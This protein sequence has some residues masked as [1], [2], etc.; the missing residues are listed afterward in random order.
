MKKCKMCKSE[1]NRYASICQHCGSD[2]RFFYRFIKDTGLINIVS[3]VLL[4]FAIVQYNNARKENVLAQ[5]ANISAQKA[6]H[7][8]DSINNHFNKLT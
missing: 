2:Q 5:E 3:I 7:S 4:V 6:L 1:I 8:I